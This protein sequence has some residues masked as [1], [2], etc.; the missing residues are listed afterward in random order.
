MQPLAPDAYAKLA[1]PD[2]WIEDAMQ[3]VEAAWIVSKLKGAKRVLD[4]GHGS[5]IVATALRDAG[6]DVTVVEGASD[7]IGR[8]EG[9]TYVHSMFEDYQPAQRFDCVIA[10]FVLEHVHDP[11][12]LLARARGWSERLIA[13]IGNAESWH[14]RVAVAMGLQPE[15]D[16]LSARDKVVGHLRVYDQA[17]FERHLMIAG[18]RASELKGVMFKPLNNALLTRLPQEVVEGFCKVDVHPRVA[19]NI[20]AYC[21]GI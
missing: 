7:F 13:V 10:S 21:Y 17:L 16:T 3:R 11:V 14:R 4:L 19:A 8:V 1:L 20:A 9:V 12:E 15:L 5:G 2:Q 6:K 18:W